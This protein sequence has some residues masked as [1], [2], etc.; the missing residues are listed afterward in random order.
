MA[1]SE[2]QN[3]ELIF[4]NRTGAAVNDIMS[5]DKAN[6]ALNEINGNIER[7]DWKA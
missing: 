1:L 4:E 6:K 7:V 2:K 3:K 5:N